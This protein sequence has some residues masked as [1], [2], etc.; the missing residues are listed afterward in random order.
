VATEAS[1]RGHYLKDLIHQFANGA[2][3]I[4]RGCPELV[5]LVERGVLDGPE[6]EAAVRACTVPLLAEGIDQLVLGCTHF[7]AMRPV[8]ER[9]AG[10]AVAV[11]DS[12]A[13]VARQARRVLEREGWLAIPDGRAVSDPRPLR[14]DDEFWCS[15]DVAVFERTASAILGEAVTARHATSV[16][17]CPALP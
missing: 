14:P 12:G 16:P 9:V 13:A 3:V 10:P 6:A 5:L 11:V 4:A 8:F 1:A 15:G 17:G 7:P 2:R